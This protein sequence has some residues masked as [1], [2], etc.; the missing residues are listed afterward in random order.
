MGQRVL[1]S[2]FWFLEKRLGDKKKNEPQRRKGDDGFW[3]TRK[4]T[5]KPLNTLKALKILEYGKLRMVNGVTITCNYSPTTIHE[6]R[7]T[8]HERL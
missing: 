6:I 8:L 1:V 3:I 7:F 4:I 2:C 5:G